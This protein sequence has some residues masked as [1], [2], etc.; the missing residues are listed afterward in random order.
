MKKIRIKWLILGVLFALT[1]VYFVSLGRFDNT[2]E[3]LRSNILRMHIIAN[4]DS[5]I[6][7]SVKLKIRDALI[8]Q[9]GDNFE[10]CKTLKSAIDFSENNLSKIEAI[11]NS[12]LIDEGLNYSATASVNDERF[13]TRIYDKFTLPA[14]EYKSLTIRL[15]NSA[16]QNWWCV[17]YPSVCLS[18]AVDFSKDIGDE[19]NEVAVR[20]D[21]YIV[22]FWVVELYQKICDFFEK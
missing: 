3:Q 18:S 10:E 11:A 8:T 2:C 12:V 7:Q 4:S 14:G 15:G 22:K 9:M 1:A 16:G 20:Q 17:M 13:S 21:K 5:D 6:D 19:P